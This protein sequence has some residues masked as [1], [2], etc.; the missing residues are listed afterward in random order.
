MIAKKSNFVF[1][2]FFNVIFRFIERNSSVYRGY[3][4]AKYI[5][6]PPYIIIAVVYIYLYLFMFISL[7]FYPSYNNCRCVYIYI[8]LTWLDRGRPCF[9]IFSRKLKF[10]RTIGFC[11]SFRI[12]TRHASSGEKFFLKKISPL[13]IQTRI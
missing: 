5:F 6:H 1:S 9:I 8:F 2:L 10:F 7:Y 11:P 13:R 12:A 4:A 3:Q